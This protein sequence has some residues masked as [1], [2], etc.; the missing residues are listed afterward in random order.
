MQ[1]LFY[2]LVLW[3]PLVCSAQ[4]TGQYH[5]AFSKAVQVWDL[6]GTYAYTN[7]GFE[8]LKSIVHSPKGGVTGGG[9]AHFVEGFT[10]IEASETS[11]GQVKGHSKGVVTLNSSGQG[12]FEG[13]AL[14][15]N[16]SG[17]FNGNLTVTLDPMTQ[18]LSGN[19][20]ATFCVRGFGCRNL[21]TN[22]TFA[23]PDEMTGAWA[24]TMDIGTTNNAVRGMATVELSN[25][26]SL[27]FRVRGRYRAASGLTTLRLNGQGPAYGL[28]LRLTLDSA[29]TLQQ[30]GG[31][32][33]GQKLVYP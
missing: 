23:L 15:R 10:D 13:Q 27:S 29:G 31:K 30:L 17:P 28:R 14:G 5:F 32:L 25:G 7:A 19:Q 33:F 1:R 4:L 22:V 12:Q 9:N 18:T 26:R 2:A 24:V 20:T 6:S 16:V 21:S 3:V 8:L 11:T